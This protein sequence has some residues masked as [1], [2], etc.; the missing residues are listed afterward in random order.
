[1]SSLGGS[2]SFVFFASGVK[3]LRVKDISFLQES[4]TATKLPG[5]KKQC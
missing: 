5:G 4:L 3:I 1:M 2:A